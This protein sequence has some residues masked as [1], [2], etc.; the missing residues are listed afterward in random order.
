VVRRG[1]A[2][3]LAGKKSSDGRKDL[4]SDAEQLAIL[5]HRVGLATNCVPQC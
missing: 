4:E 2:K 5:R 1:D 3:D